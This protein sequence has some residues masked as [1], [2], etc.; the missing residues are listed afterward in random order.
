MNAKVIPPP[1]THRPPSIKQL[2]RSMSAA[3]IVTTNL[4]SPTASNSSQTGTYPSKAQEARSTMEMLSRYQSSPS[5]QGDG[6]RRSSE[7]P[8]KSQDAT[9]RMAGSTPRR[10][11]GPAPAPPPYAPKV[12]CSKSS[13]ERHRTSL[14]GIAEKKLSDMSLASRSDRSC[15]K[16]DGAFLADADKQ[17]KERHHRKIDIFPND[18]SNNDHIKSR[19]SRSL[20]VR[21]TSNDSDSLSRREKRPRS[22]PNA[23]VI[24]HASSESCLNT[25]CGYPV[26]E[27]I[28]FSIDEPIP[29]GGNEEAASKRSSPLSGADSATSLQSDMSARELV[30]LCAK[31]KLT[32]PVSLK[33][34]DTCVL[35]GRVVEGGSE[36]T[37]CAVHQR[38]AAQLVDHGQCIIYESVDGTAPVN[39]LYEVVRGSLEVGCRPQYLW[40]IQ[41]F[42]SLRKLLSEN[43]SRRRIKLNSEVKIDDDTVLKKDE[44]FVVACDDIVADA[45]THVPCWRLSM[46][47]GLHTTTHLPVQAGKDIK[48][49]WR[50]VELIMMPLDQAAEFIVCVNSD[51]LRLR[52]IVKRYSRELPVQ[53]LAC[54]YVSARPAPFAMSGDPSVQCRLS[55]MSEL[56]LLTV[57]KETVLL[58]R[59]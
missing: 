13:V 44:Q 2:S 14:T 55:T 40:S 46:S 21:H 59:S 7:D 17:A 56:S 23:F 58:V 49:P 47:S 12:L 50:A 25:A 52:E 54:E 20:T 48:L 34:N 6:A 31:N 36:A 35:G 42:A 39:C 45:L 3:A 8:R 18:C 41:S 5:T 38:A 19:D 16:L 11:K 32:L 9:I 4:R 27:N 37:L 43:P 51:L 53:V 22:S 15:D 10:P 24:H 30:A 33:V 28:Y 57:I 26:T 29:T 1:P